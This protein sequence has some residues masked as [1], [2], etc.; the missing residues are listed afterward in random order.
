MPPA[1]T[2]ATRPSRNLAIILSEAEQTSVSPTSVP[3]ASARATSAG[4][5]SG[6]GA[7]ASARIRA[8]AV[9]DLAGREVRG[10][11]AAFAQ[12]SALVI[13]V[14]PLLDHP[15]HPKGPG[16]RAHQPCVTR[17]TRLREAL[18]TGV[19]ATPRSWPAR[20]LAR[21]LLYRESSHHHTPRIAMP[22]DTLQTIDPNELTR[23][24]GGT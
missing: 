1:G 4:G 17:R 10:G 3:V 24:S 22:T 11:R 12:R 16:G 15:H 19:G 23:V 7:E 5:V 13:A 9:L 8:G 21:R 6:G 2:P 14:K 18:P 20:R